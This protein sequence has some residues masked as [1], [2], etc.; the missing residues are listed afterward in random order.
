VRSH[1]ERAVPDQ[2]E[3][4]LEQGLIAHVGFVVDGAP[5]VIPMGYHYEDGTIYIH[6]QRGG[7][8]PRTLRAGE[9]VCVEV[10]L[11]DALLASRDDQPDAP[12]SAGIVPVPQR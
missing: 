8:L 5:I 1:P 2:A 9:P 3:A 4:I 12:G 11:L 6:G 7:R 10:T